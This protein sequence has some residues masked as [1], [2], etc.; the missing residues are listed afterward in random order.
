MI[1]RACYYR[2]Q[3]FFHRLT[4]TPDQSILAS[5]G[6]IQKHPYWKAINF[7]DRAAGA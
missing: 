3:S 1:I 6:D 4:R 7:A 2:K 5:F